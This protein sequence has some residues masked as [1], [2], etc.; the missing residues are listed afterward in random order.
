[1]DG[2][3]RRIVDLHAPTAGF[4]TVPLVSGLPDGRHVVRLVV[5]GTH[6]ADSAG[7]GVAIDG[8]LV[9]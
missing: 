2:V 3:F 6:R 1:M 5:L 7:D 4:A 9:V 8:W